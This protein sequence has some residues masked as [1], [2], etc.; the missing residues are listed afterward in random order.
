MKKIL[1]TAVL[2]ASLVACDKKAETTDSAPTETS[3]T[4]TQATETQASNDSSADS[5]S[6]A[7]FSSPEVQKVADEYATFVKEYVEAYKSGDATK[8]HDLAK[9]QQEWATK[10]QS[11]MSSM[12]PEDVKVWTEYMQKL[13]EEMTAATMPAK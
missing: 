3:N 2:V 5:S 1:L 9:K 13:S 4:E 12:T 8:I 7:K 11:S 6:S 10:L